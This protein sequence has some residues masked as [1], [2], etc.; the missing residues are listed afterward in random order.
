MR[1]RLEACKDFTTDPQFILDAEVV[2]KPITTENACCGF[3][4]DI[5]SRIVKEAMFPAV[6]T[7]TG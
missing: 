5:W 2:L 1:E 6:K 4:A 3:S 7:C